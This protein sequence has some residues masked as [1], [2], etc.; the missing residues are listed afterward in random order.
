MLLL[1][2]DTETTGLDKDNNVI[3]EVAAVLY[4]FEDKFYAEMVSFL[5][6][7]GVE[8]DEIIKEIT[9]IQDKHLIKYSTDRWA[10]VQEMHDKCDYV[11]AHNAPFDVG[12]LE[13]KINFN[14]PV[15][16]TLVDIP[17]PKHTNTR[18]LKYAATD[19]GF[20]NNFA[21]RAL[22]DVV[23]MLQILS[24][25]DINVVIER[26]KSRLIKIIAQTSYEDRQLAKDAGFYWDPDIKKWSKKMKEL[27]YHYNN[28]D[29]KTVEVKI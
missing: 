19:H 23:T 8:L 14:K 6:N 15:I 29:F 1:G 4:D 13:K 16:D 3:I 11:V 26:S 5:S 20:A 21:H 27:D 18:K 24:C 9:G 12:F 25:Y 17:W 22:F 28:Y 7:P 10:Q 2:T